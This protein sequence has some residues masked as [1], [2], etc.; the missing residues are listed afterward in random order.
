MVI[1]VDDSL[2]TNGNDDI[3]D[4]ELADDTTLTPNDDDSVIVDVVND[5]SSVERGVS[6]LIEKEVTDTGVVVDTDEDDNSG[7]DINKDVNNAELEDVLPEEG[8][9]NAPPDSNVIDDSCELCI[10]V[11]TLPT[12]DDDEN[13]TKVEPEVEA[14]PASGEDTVDNTTLTFDEVAVVV[15]VDGS[16]DENAT[17][18]PD[19]VLTASDALLSACVDTENSIER[20]ATTLMENEVMDTGAAADN[21]VG[22]DDATDV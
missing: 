6:T 2:N 17:A 16:G 3:S 21:D 12:T 15:E 7:V 19:I 10:W 8:E 20:A 11:D 4:I 14:E 5:G 9:D 13:D 1:A 22:A 18:D